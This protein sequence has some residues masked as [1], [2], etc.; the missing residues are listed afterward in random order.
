[1]TQFAI[2]RCGLQL[3]TF[4]VMFFL[5]FPIIITLVVAINPREFILPP[6]GI[7]LRWFTAAWTS[8]TFLHAMGVS[9]CLA[10]ASALLA[11]AL[12]LP[13]AIA[14]TRYQFAGKKLINMFIMSPLLIPTA[15]FSLALYIYFVKMGLGAGLLPLLIGH[16]LHL[17]SVCVPHAVGQPASIR[18]L[19]RR[20]GAQR[21][22]GAV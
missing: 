5:V 18:R 7:T 2:R 8:N 15:I 4:L 21:G 17:D 22:R 10:I 16:T 1:M 6:T 12:V 9:F 14:F 19:M 11:N 20:G 13:A 3:F